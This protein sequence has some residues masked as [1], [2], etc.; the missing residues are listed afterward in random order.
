VTPA[1]DASPDPAKVVLEE[2]GRM[3]WK[4]EEGPLPRLDARLRRVGEWLLVGY[5]VAMVLV[6]FVLPAPQR[7]ADPA[8]PE[9]PVAMFVG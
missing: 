2:V 8:A 3:E 4:T 7:R 5:T 9:V 6:S 1:Q